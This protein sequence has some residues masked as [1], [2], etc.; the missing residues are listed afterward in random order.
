ML[1]RSPASQRFQAVPRWNTEVAERLRAMEKQ[2]LSSCRPLDLS[3]PLYIFISEEP[4][5][6]S[7]AEASYQ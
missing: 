1:S 2:Q 7:A 4:L 5:G 3:E 6:V